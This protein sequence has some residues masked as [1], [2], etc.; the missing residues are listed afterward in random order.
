[1]PRGVVTTVVTHLEM[2]APPV[3]RTPIGAVGRR[4]V[5]IKDPT[6]DWYR[7]L[8]RS[9][10]TEWLWWSRLAMD[11]AEL[12]AIIEDENVEIFALREDGRDLGL[13]ELDFRDRGDCELA[14]FGLIRDAIGTGG[15]RLML[16]HAIAQAWARDIGKFWVHTCT[17]DDPR[18]L[19]FYRR[20]GFSAVRQEVEVAPDPRLIGLLP[21]DAAPHVPIL[22]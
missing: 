11:D 7:Q 15:G 16:E 5:R 14:F 18:A 9:V 6:L 4:L 12:R 13:L 21:E 1:M 3:P 8:Y 20:S 2:T 19:G 10:G 17:L 22:P